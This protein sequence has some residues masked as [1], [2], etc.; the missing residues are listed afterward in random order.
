M[1]V[2]RE[3]ASK[4][5]FFRSRSGQP[6]DASALVSRTSGS[7]YDVLTVVDGHGAQRAMLARISSAVFVH[8]YGYPAVLEASMNSR[9]A[10]SSCATLRYAP[11]RN[12]LFVSSANQRS[13]TFSHEP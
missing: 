8:T 10:A 3:R 5:Q 11:R 7:L 1:C 12:C 4:Q 9:M 6:V 2:A 13:T